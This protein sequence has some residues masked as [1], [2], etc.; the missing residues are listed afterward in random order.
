I[1]NALFLNQESF[2]ELQ[3]NART[4]AGLEEWL[5]R[6]TT[7]EA[8]SRLATGGEPQVSVPGRSVS[9]QTWGA[10]QRQFTIGEGDGA[11][12]QLR[13]FFYPFWELRTS[14][15]SALSTRPDVNG[16]L[17]TD[18]PAGP[19]TIEMNFVRPRYQ[20]MANLL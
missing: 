9:I 19:Q 11:V 3:Q 14:Q 20:M 17:L 1:R 4:S 18:I 2:T 16:V 7:A 13:T 10:E 6:W 15:G 12:A 8:A 5:P